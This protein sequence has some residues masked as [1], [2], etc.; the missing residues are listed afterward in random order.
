MWEYGYKEKVTV[1]VG[2]RKLDYRMWLEMVRRMEEW[3][4]RKELE[5]EADEKKI[6]RERSWRFKIRK[7][8]KE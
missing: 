5:D 7:W 3:I 1:G 2:T 8:T 4:R 6:A